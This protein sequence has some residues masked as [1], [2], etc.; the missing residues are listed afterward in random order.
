MIHPFGAYREA[1]FLEDP[2]EIERLVAEGESWRF[3]EAV[4]LAAEP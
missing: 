3:T 4:M 2:V 1:Q